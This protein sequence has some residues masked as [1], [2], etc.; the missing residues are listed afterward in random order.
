MKSFSKPCS[1]RHSL[2]VKIAALITSAAL[3]GSCSLVASEGSDQAENSGQS[4]AEGMQRVE[5]GR[6]SLEVPADWEETEDFKPT[7]NGFTT[8]WSNAD[9]DAGKEP[10]DVVRLSSDQ[11]QGPT[12]TATMGYFE[13]NAQFQTTHGKE[14]E[15]GESRDLD[16]ENA[17]EAKLTTWTTNEKSGKTL[18]G[19]WVFVS[20]GGGGAA[21]V[22]ILSLTLSEDEIEAI[23]DSIKFDP[24]KSDESE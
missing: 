5:E 15:L 3:L 2:P 10:T 12:A 7:E 4:A 24:N 22:E 8:S 23:I 1:K 20:A 6:I 14:F 13:V 21:G 18:Q 9:K 16:I 19:A 11:G 17:D